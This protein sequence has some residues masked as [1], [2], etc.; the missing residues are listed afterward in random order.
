MKR[1]VLASKGAES[2]AGVLSR[3]D[4]IAS[5]NFNRDVRVILRLLNEYKKSRQL[6]RMS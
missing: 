1:V 6:T 5:D 2:E 4:P 3:R